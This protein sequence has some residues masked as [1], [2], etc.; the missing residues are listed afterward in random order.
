MTPCKTQPAR[1]LSVTFRGLLLASAAAAAFLLAG[2]SVANAQTLTVDQANGNSPYTVTSNATFTQVTVGQS[3]TGVLNHSAGALSVTANSTL[4]LAYTSTANGTYNLS[5]TGALSASDELIGSYGIG[6]FNQSGGTNTVNKLYLSVQYYTSGT[7]NLSGSGILSA[8]T[9]IIGYG[10]D[11]NG[12]FNQ[13]GGTNN[14]ALDLIIGILDPD[15]GIYN[16]NGGTLAA[17]S[18]NSGNQSARGTSTFNFNGGTLQA[19]GTN[20]QFFH[21]LTTANVQAGGAKID[22]NGFD[23]AVQQ[24]LL[25]DTTVGAPATDGGLTKSGAGKLTLTAA[26]TYTGGTTFAAGTLNLSSAGALGSS[27]TLLFTG[28]SLQFSAAN[29]TDY[30]G[31]FRLVSNQ[32]YSIDTYGQNV[33]FGNALTSSGG[34]LTKLGPGTLT[35]AATN[36]YTG[37]TTVSGG[38]L[39]I[40]GRLANTNGIVLNNGGTLGLSGSNAVTDRLNNAAPVTVNG[41]GTFATGSLK[42]GTAPTA[43]GGVGGAAGLAALTLSATSSSAP[44]IFD[45]ANTATGSTLVFSGLTAGSQGA[46]VKVLNWTGTPGSDAGSSTNDRLLFQTNPGFTAADLANVQFSNDSGVNYV[47]GALLINYNG[48]YEL[49]PPATQPPAITSANST[50]FTVGTA[51]T[52]T[53]T[54]TGFPAPTLSESGT[55][56]SGVTFNATTGVLS[57]T[58]AAGTGGAYPI[59]FTASNGVG[60]DAVQSFTLT[61][62]QAPA[63]TSANSTTFAIGTA[64][65]FTVTKT[66]FPAPTLSQSGTLPSGVTFNATTGV[67]SGTPGAGTTGVYPITFTA[68]NGVG[69]NAVQSFSLTVGQP[70]AITSAN[71]TTFVAGTAGTF[72]VTVTGFPAPS[73]SEGGTLP[74]GVTFNSA[75]G[76]LSG[77]PAAST[78]GVYPIFF[79]AGNGVGSNAVQSFTLTVN[80]APAITSA[81]NATFTVGQAG[82]F[83]VTATGFPSPTFSETGALAAGLAF[84]ANTGVLSGTP[85]PDT[86]GSYPVTMMASNG[87]GSAA[88]QPFTLTVNAIPCTAAVSGMIMWL[89]A[90]N[91]PNDLI[92][93]N[94]A[95]LQSGATYSTGEV[96]QAF[97][98]VNAANATS[99]QYVNVVTP[100]GLPVGNAARTVEMW[101]NT[102]TTLASSPNAALFQYGTATIEKSFGLVFTAANPG[103]LM[104]NGSGDDLLGTTTVTPN[105]WHHVAVTYDGATV[106]LYLDGALEGTKA[107][108]V[109]NTTLDGNGLSI[110]SRP[111]VSVFNGKLDEVQIFNRALTQ[112]EIQATYYAGAQGTCAPPLNLTS[113]VSRRTHA[114][115]PL[116]VS[117]PLVGTAGIEPRTSTPAGNH[118]VVFTFTHSVSGG[119]VSVTSGTGTAGAPTYSGNS[120]TVNLSGVTDAQRITLTLN[121]VTDAL[122]QVLATTGM[123]MAVLACDVNGDGFV[124]ASDATVARNG[125]GQTATAAN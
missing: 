62:N 109:L 100:I 124:N 58:P 70:P 12:T 66:G 107:T 40:S 25:H 1:S 7:Y 121:G 96:G 108:S 31:R 36:T 48:Y 54:K 44:A 55:L 89:P 78:G 118:T 111:G 6:T 10:Y 11:T 102:A 5:G 91:N 23:V 47:S 86:Q 95:V 110:G 94:N 59:T 39:A 83:N 28:G 84:A 20:G 9:E 43:P 125:S 22:S 87:V 90:N 42:E 32:A 53:V 104:F 103:K 97:N 13:S 75:T 88:T 106:K 123:N 64:G 21:D 112:A 37:A 4:Y 76:V 15:N 50:T 35:L 56:P 27:G 38:I 24:T 18:V 60:S 63:I 45:F 41:G 119:T 116:D 120:M 99:G 52:F 117:L 74:S 17:N 82:S 51:G 49:V 26:N 14:V 30:S 46:F 101:F 80:Q 2:P 98:L 113:A 29:T 3:G 122:G 16:L 73:V 72:T 34:T 105:A 68:T 71:S 67:L 114:G 19:R 65:T 115:T 93:S 8:N 92:G 33:S 57:G 77:T 61:V 69:S 85:R 81:N 79:F